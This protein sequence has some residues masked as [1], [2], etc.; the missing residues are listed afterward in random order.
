MAGL[1]RTF[2]ADEIDTL[3][4][5]LGKKKILELSVLIDELGKSRLLDILQQE[6]S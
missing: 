5:E 4:D 2:S 3:V 1:A 6:T